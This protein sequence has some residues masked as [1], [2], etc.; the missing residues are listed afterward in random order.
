MLEKPETIQ[1]FL[2]KFTK[3]NKPDTSLL[4][5][6]IDILIQSG[7]NFTVTR[8]NVKSDTNY[9]NDETIYVNACG[10]FRDMNVMASRTLLVNPEDSQKHAYQVANETLDVLIKNL[11]VG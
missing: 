8:F 3:E 7:G 4:E 11:V 5:Y 10:K 6:P 9:L 2:A 1:K